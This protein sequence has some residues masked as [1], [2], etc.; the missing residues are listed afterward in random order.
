MFSL[1][2]LSP[3]FSLF[4]YSF[5]F[6]TTPSPLFPWSPPLWVCFFPLCSINHLW[7]T[8]KVLSSPLHCSLV[9]T[10]IDSLLNSHWNLDLCLPATTSDRW[11]DQIWNMLQ[12]FLL[13]W[14]TIVTWTILSR[15][16]IVVNHRHML[17]VWTPIANQRCL[18]IHSPA[19][20]MLEGNAGVVIFKKISTTV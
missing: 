10:I 18:R 5:H 7:V 16:A 1:S 15:G 20:K 6:H 11:P 13:G 12:D 8:I 9:L 14:A 19:L 4:S 3:T 2:L 17:S